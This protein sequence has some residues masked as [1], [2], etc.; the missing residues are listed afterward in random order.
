[1]SSASLCTPNSGHPGLWSWFLGTTSHGQCSMERKHCLICSFLKSTTL[2]SLYIKS[3]WG[4]NHLSFENFPLGHLLFLLIQRIFLFSL[5]KS[6]NFPR[7]YLCY[8]LVSVSVP[9]WMVCLFHKQLQGAFCL[10]EKPLCVFVILLFI[11]LSGTLIVWMLDLL[12]QPAM[13]IT[14]SWIFSENLLV[15]LRLQPFS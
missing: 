10:P 5:N 1:M 2:F 11:S 4:K 3:C 6:S 14:Q 7:L 13:L 9:R 12:C 15:S 8:W